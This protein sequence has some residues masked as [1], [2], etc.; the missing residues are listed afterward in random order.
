MFRPC[1]NIQ[2]LDVHHSVLATQHRLQQV[3]Q[4][5]FEL[6]EAYPVN[7]PKSD[8]YDVPGPLSVYLKNG[9]TTHRDNDWYVVVRE[10]LETP[11]RTKGVTPPQQKKGVYH[12]FADTKYSR[13]GYCDPVS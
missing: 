2:L 3:L 7:N 1:F 12:K 8:A 11:A 10:R 5:G 6:A 4:K 13:L 9:F